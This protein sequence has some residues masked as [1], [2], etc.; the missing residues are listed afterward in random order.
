MRGA[1]SL[2]RPENFT[3]DAAVDNTQI[4]TH[5]K[6]VMICVNFFYLGSPIAPFELLLGVSQTNVNLEFGVHVQRSHQA[7]PRSVHRHNNHRRPM[8]LEELAVECRQLVR[9]FNGTYYQE[10]RFCT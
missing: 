9:Y 3:I 2:V 6:F 5:K 7:N 1:A 8:Q 10:R 4:E